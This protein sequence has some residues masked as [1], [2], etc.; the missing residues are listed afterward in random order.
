[1]CNNGTMS[2]CPSGSYS[3]VGSSSCLRCPSGSYC[4]NG[5]QTV[6]SDGTF[7]LSD[8]KEPEDCL[9]CDPGHKCVRG[10]KAEC[11]FESYSLGGAS[12][13]SNCLTGNFCY[14]LDST[15]PRFRT[16]HPDLVKIMYLSSY[17]LSKS[18]RPRF[19]FFIFQLLGYQLTMMLC[20][21]LLSTFSFY[22]VIKR[23]QEMLSIIRRRKSIMDGTLVCYYFIN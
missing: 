11:P 21:A 20:Y 6:C 22:F 5:N 9:P 10:I 8:S 16:D 15:V 18:H 14:V 4:Q 2:M 13:C 7:S 23:W 17:W 12:A 1:M 3:N 19:I